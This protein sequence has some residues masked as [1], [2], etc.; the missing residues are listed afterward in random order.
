[1]YYRRFLLCV[2]SGLLWLMTAVD[3]TPPV[4]AGVPQAPVRPAGTSAS[5]G[6]KSGFTVQRIP[7]TV[8]ARMQGKSYKSGCPIPRDSLRYLKVRH[9]GFDGRVH[10]GEIVCHR[11][12]A[13]DL[14]RIFKA[15]YRARYPIERIRLVDDYGADDTRSMT[16]NNTS[17]FNYRRIAGSKRLSYHAQGRAIDINP[18]YN[19]MVSRDGRSVS[20]PAGRPYA[21][22]TRRFDHKI[23]RN[24][25]CYRLFKKYG[26]RWGGDWSGRKDYQ[27]FER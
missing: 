24:D 13:D 22:R 2:M 20:P 18:L 21:D 27:H 23:D 1:M 12:V 5:K 14:L 25:L 7:D 11:R 19:P 4:T 8:F 17:C 6:E 16:A 26:F 9:Y 15:L 3:T 10:T